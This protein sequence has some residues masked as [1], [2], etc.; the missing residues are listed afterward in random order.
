MSRILKCRCSGRRY[1][2]VYRNIFQCIEQP[3]TFSLQLPSSSS[4]FTRSLLISYIPETPF[5]FLF[6]PTSTVYEWM[7]FGDLGSDGSF[8]LIRHHPRQEW[9][10]QPRSSKFQEVRFFVCRHLSLSLSLLLHGLNAC[11]CPRHISRD[12]SI[13]SCPSPICTE[14]RCPCCTNPL[15]RQSTFF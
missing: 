13:S 6:W 4:D 10:R 2:T 14:C 1:R 8:Y 9:R 15:G 5:G 3:K 11:W 12:V 7:T